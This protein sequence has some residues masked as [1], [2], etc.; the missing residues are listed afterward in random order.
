MG[1]TAYTVDDEY[2]IHYT[3]VRKIPTVQE[4]LTEAFDAPYSYSWKTDELGDT[5]AY[6]DLP[7]GNTMH[8]EFSPGA[9]D[10]VELS[11]TRNQ[12]ALITGEGD[13]YRI[14]ATVMAAVR[15]YIA[16]FDPSKITFSAVKEWHT[17]DQNYDD[18]VYSGASRIKLYNR[19]VKAY[20]AKMGYTARA[21]DAKDTVDYV[22]TKTK[23]DRITEGAVPNN[24]KVRTINKLLSRPFP[25]SDIK[26]QMDAFFAIPDP[27]MIKAFRQARAEKGDNTS[28]HPVLRTFIKTLHPAI[29]KGIKLYEQPRKG[30]Q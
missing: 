15:D 2:G 20:A 19:M 6:V 29:Q 11:F 7:G 13:A 14:F 21:Q 25:A 4:S 8:I 18:V 28:L 27:S 30:P 17:T 5:S 16:E 24:D 22:L 23:T 9:G 26:G 3:M 12:S 1:Y 10:E